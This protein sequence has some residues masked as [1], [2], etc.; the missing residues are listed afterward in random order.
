MEACPLYLPTCISRG[1][2]CYTIFAAGGFDSWLRA[3]FLYN[4]RAYSHAPR[5]A[6]Y[7]LF[8]LL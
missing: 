7:K 5:P 2:C 4:Q 3:A 6:S 1:T 8:T